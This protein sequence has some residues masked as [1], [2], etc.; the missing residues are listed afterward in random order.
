MKQI[1]GKPLKN[2][3]PD[4]SGEIT[5][6]DIVLFHPTGRMAKVWLMWETVRRFA[7]LL[8]DAHAKEILSLD[9]ILKKY[10]G[11]EILPDDE[12][13]DLLELTDLHSRTSLSSKVLVKATVLELL[14][15]FAEFAVKEIVK[16]VEPGQSPPRKW[17]K[18]INIL[19]VKG[20]FTEFPESY[21]KHVQD[22][23]EP[24]RNNFAHGNWEQLVEEVEFVD[25]DE[26][27]WG[28]VEFVGSMQ[29]KL[30][31]H[32]YDLTSPTITPVKLPEG[33]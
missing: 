3:G 4:V 10:E 7:T 27:L 22:H 29:W 2:L 31:E 23:R 25:L 15:G 1:K 8:D 6:D 33:F 17:E 16:L 30:E 5:I 9:N 32:G 24:V 20:I 18:L 14:S 28:T 26:A 19:R 13:Q 12:I 21:E 11:S